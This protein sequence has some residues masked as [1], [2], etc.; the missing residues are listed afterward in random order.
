MSCPKCKMSMGWSEPELI[1][2]DATD[3][4]WF[5]RKSRRV[6]K[7]CKY[8][9]TVFV[10]PYDWLYRLLIFSLGVIIFGS[11]QFYASNKKIIIILFSLWF[12]GLF[13]TIISSKDEE[14]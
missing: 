11:V 2:N 13:I 7:R 6:G 8:C 14:L 1:E 10:N 9:N 12:V 5:K 4:S 3:S